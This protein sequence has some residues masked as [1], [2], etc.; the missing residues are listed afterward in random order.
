MT[1][2]GHPRKHPSVFPPRLRHWLTVTFTLSGGPA[3]KVD[4]VGPSQRKLPDRETQVLVVKNR[5]GYHMIKAKGSQGL[6]W[7]KKWGHVINM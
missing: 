6:E 2:S 1:T 4:K 3:L 7:Q 5:W